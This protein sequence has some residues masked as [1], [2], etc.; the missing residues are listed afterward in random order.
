MKGSVVDNN[1]RLKPMDQ[2]VGLNGK[3]LLA[4]SKE[5]IAELLKVCSGLQ[6]IPLLNLLLYRIVYILL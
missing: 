6:A 4:A 2:L 5:E 3:D 1:G